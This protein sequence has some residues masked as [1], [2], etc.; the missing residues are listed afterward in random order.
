METIENHLQ[1]IG[2]L[3]SAAVGV[4]RCFIQKEHPDPSF[5]PIYCSTGLAALH[6][7]YRYPS[8]GQFQKYPP[9]LYQMFKK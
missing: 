8:E 9:L 7:N 2:T 1:I 4:K 5:D 3:S 6:G